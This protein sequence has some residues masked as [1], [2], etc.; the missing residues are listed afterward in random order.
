MGGRG[1]E[2]KQTQTHTCLALRSRGQAGQ[3]AGLCLS[4]NGLPH[5]AIPGCEL[6]SLRARALGS[7]DGL[8]ILTQARLPLGPLRTSLGVV[9]QNPQAWW[10]LVLI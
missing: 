8:I 6:G 9:P 3:A 5:P 4:L 7:A 2:N 10:A 1:K